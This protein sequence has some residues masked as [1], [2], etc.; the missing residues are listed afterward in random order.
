MAESF[1]E[2]FEQSLK[3]INMQPGSIVSGTVVDIDSDWI[4]VHAGL[5]PKVSFPRIS[6]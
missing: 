6:F 3:E 5:S 4:T 1:S 2:L